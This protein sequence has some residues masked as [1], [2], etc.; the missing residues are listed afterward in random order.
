MSIVSVLLRRFKSSRF[1]R[2]MRLAGRASRQR[3]WSAAAGRYRAAVALRP[4]ASW[5]WIQYGHAL[6]ESNSL[7]DAA[8]AYQ[9]A[10]SRNGSDEETYYYLADLLRR[11][12]RE[13]DAELALRTALGLP[14]ADAKPSPFVLLSRARAELSIF[15]RTQDAEEQFEQVIREFPS[16]D[17][18]I[19][20]G[21]TLKDWGRHA[22][23]EAKY[24]QAL[25]M[26]PRNADAYLHLGHILKLQGRLEAAVGAYLIARNLSARSDD[27]YRHAGEELTG[28]ATAIERPVE[29]PA[30]LKRDARGAQIRS[31]VKNREWTALA[32][33]LLAI[34][35]EMRTTEVSEFTAQ[36]LMMIGDEAGAY[37]ILQGLAARG[38]Q[39]ETIFLIMARDEEGK[40][41]LPAA[42]ELYCKALAVGM[43]FGEAFEALARHKQHVRIF[44]IVERQVFASAGETVR[45]EDH[46]AVPAAGRTP[47]LLIPRTL[48]KS[49]H[50]EIS[51]QADDLDAR[52]FGAQARLFREDAA[53]LAI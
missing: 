38:H 20:Y 7:E 19:Q 12:G 4:E 34:P 29:L 8:R 22:E 33:K 36:V 24:R 41:N 3:N 49:L 16:E 17:V 39:S 2:Q 1:K 11:L 14:R 42:I 27:V 40:G 43:Q 26:S 15:G 32:D 48:A 51:K 45:F 46:V 25:E 23:A 35:V 18:L 37:S 44:D 13:R 52:G 30:E 31:L 47:G 5:A 6:K 50:D 21:H 10:V 28:L 53:H 9:V